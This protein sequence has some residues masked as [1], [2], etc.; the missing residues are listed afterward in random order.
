MSESFN[1]HAGAD[2]SA[3]DQRRKAALMGRLQA[4]S[5]AMTA[6]AMAAHQKDH[7]IVT[8]RQAGIF[9]PG[10]T[11][12]QQAADV[13]A[14]PARVGDGAGAGRDLERLGGTNWEA[15]GA[16]AVGPIPAGAYANLNRPA[17]QLGESPLLRFMRGER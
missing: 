2:P 10:A 7:N 11:G 12:Q 1:E 15:Q 9:G 16:G 13:A 6:A 4:N 3:E 5:D 17:D 8:S 14:R